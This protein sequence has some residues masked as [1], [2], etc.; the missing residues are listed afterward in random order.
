MASADQIRSSITEQIVR[1]LEGGSTPPWRRPWRSHT[2]AGRAANFV[3]RRAYTG[4]NILLLDLHAMNHKFLSRWFGTFEQWKAVGGKVRKRPDNV[5]PGEWGCQIVFYRPIFKKVVDR[6]SGEE[7]EKEF[8]LLRTFTVFNADQ[9]EGEAVEP[10]RV[11]EEPDDIFPNFEPAERLIA[12]TEA[13]IRHGGDRAVYHRPTPDGEW[14]RHTSGDF[15]E[16][17]HRRHF[18]TPGSYY[19]TVLHELAHWSEVR[20]G[21]DHRTEGYAAGELVAELAACFVAS[22]LHIPHGEA[23]ENHTAYLRSWLDAMKADP[24]FIFR[25]SSQ[26]SKVCDFLHSFAFHSMPS[27]DIAAIEVEA[28]S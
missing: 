8:R 26:A 10:F 22:E 28:A 1:A 16:V 15:I 27:E 19:E 24:S 4:I 25:A 12:A 7:K 20:S 3:S 5:P 17:P 9:V 11:T 21:W 6:Q 13:D 14:P 2:N 18:D 23:V